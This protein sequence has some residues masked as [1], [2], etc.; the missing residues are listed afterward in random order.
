M[1]SR[2]S[3]FPLIVLTT[4]LLPVWLMGCPA[5]SINT[6]DDD[7][8]DSGASDDDAVD[9]DAVDDDAADDDA[10]DDDTAEDCTVAVGPPD[11]QIELSG[12][13]HGD[14]G[15]CVGGFNPENPQGSCGAGMT[16]CV[17]TDQCEVT[18][19]FECAAASDD[20]EGEPPM[21]M[22]EFPQVGCPPETPYCCV[23][24]GEEPPQ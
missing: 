17:D 22:P 13:C 1:T 7:D 19:G 10:G 4:L 20:C 8:N 6:D 15:E 14:Q 21:G 5:G 18:M 24:M 9:D 16:C 3:F 11:V 2:I 12:S 23:E